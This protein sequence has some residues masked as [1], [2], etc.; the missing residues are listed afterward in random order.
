MLEPIPKHNITKN[1][2]N[3]YPLKSYKEK[4]KHLILIDD[5]DDDNIDNSVI[6][7]WYQEFQLT[8]N[9]EKILFNPNGWLSDQ[10]LSSTMQILYVQKLQ[11]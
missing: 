7:Y 8:K 4:D 6:D 9:N 1:V 11:S 5:L 2:Q 3:N 10:N